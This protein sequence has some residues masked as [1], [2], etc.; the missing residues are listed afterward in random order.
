MKPGHPAMQARTFWKISM[1]WTMI[2]RIAIFKV[3]N[4][5]ISDP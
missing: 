4:V 1:E 2:S 5:Q 3:D